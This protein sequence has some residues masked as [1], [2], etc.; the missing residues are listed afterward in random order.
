MTVTS[1]EA[2]FERSLRTLRIIIAALAVGAAGVLG[3]LAYLRHAG[4]A[5]PVPAVPMITYVA[6][7]FGLSALAAYAFLPNALAAAARRRIARGTW[8]PAPGH[9]ALSQ[10]LG[11]GEKLLM[12]YQTRQIMSAALLEGVA[13]FLATAYFVEGVP[14]SLAAAVALVGALAAHFPTRSGVERWVEGQLDL[15]RRDRAGQ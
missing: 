10:P 6:I 14:W 8:Q 11:D 3:I 9:A 13:F 2:F 12:V 1:G 5:K 7:P 15:L 4:P